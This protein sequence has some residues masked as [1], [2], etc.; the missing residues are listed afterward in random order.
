MSFQQ[1][2]EA[3]KRQRELEAT[4]RDLTKEMPP[5]GSTGDSLRAIRGMENIT[6]EMLR[7]R[8]NFNAKDP[9]PAAREVGLD[10]RK[11]SPE[12]LAAVQ[13]A[14]EAEEKARNNNA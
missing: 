4:H 10:F 8:A 5:P 7:E 2:P 13:Q 3:A 12:E 9:R 6:D 11:M 14:A 1:S